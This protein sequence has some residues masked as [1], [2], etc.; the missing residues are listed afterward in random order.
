MIGTLIV[1]VITMRSRVAVE[2]SLQIAVL[3]MT[4]SVRYLCYSIQK[5][6]IKGAI[7]LVEHSWGSHFLEPVGS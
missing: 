2:I 6:K 1:A 5:R 7:L 3:N 4:A